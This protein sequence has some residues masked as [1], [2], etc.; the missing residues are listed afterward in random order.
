MTDD[1]KE[2]EIEEYKMA[3]SLFDKDRD[4]TIDEKELG[5]VMRML[6]HNVTDL[7]IR[8]LIE[9]ADGDGDG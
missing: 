3:F 7:E 8:G 9:L 6:G 1:L 4:G 2:G 5:P